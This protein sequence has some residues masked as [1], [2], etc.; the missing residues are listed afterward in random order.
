MNHS[1]KLR[2]LGLIL[3]GV[4]S[5]ASAWFCTH[6]LAKDHHV[7]VV[8]CLPSELIQ[9]LPTQEFVRVLNEAVTNA[10]QCSSNSV[11]GLV[12]SDPTIATYA[13]VIIQSYGIG[14]ERVTV[15]R[16]PPKGSAIRVGACDEA[17]TV[18]TTPPLGTTV[19]TQ[20][21]STAVIVLGNRPLDDA[22]PTVE[23]V[24]RVL[25]AVDFV[26]EK[27]NAVLVM[28]GGP[29][30]GQVSEAKMMGLIALSRDIPRHRVVLEEHAMSTDA[31]AKLTALIVI[32]LGAKTV[33]V[34]SNTN[35]LRWAMPLFLS[36]PVFTDAKPLESPDRRE[37]TQRQIEQQLL[38][39]DSDLLRKRLQSLKEGRS[40]VD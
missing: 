2:L 9:G 27:D 32:E 3:V 34:C 10:R 37:E 23:L 19:S 40:G 4:L 38:R 17:K 11:L 24:Q 35:H 1:G 21:F 18:R 12:T 14:E 26:R 8:A 13:A 20:K 36:Q 16:S 29:T 25:T 30:A 39:R 22:T 31:N 7:D 28:T 6:G 15:L 5:V 33:Y